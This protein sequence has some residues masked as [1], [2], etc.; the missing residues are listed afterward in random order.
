MATARNGRRTK[1]TDLEFLH[2]FIGPCQHLQTKVIWAS[3][4][5]F[6]CQME[7]KLREV[8]IRCNAVRPLTVDEIR[9]N[10]GPRA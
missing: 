8:K 5:Y 10:L 2:T 3:Q 1:M 4:P 7:V 9:A 6:A